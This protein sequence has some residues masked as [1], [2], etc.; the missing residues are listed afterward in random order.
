MEEREGDMAYGRKVKGRDSQVIQVLVSPVE[1]LVFL[2]E[3][4]RGKDVL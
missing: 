3:Q 2:L 4:K 1:D